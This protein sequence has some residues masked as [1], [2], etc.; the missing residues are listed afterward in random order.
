M[1]FISS[2]DSDG[3]HL[4]HSKSDNRNIMTGFD[5]VENIEELFDLLA[6]MY[7]VD[8]EKSM[9]GSE[10]VFECIDG[11]YYKCHKVSLNRGGSYIN[12]HK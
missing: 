5:T 11:F 8:L 7:Q 1:K 4:M 12:S 2:E 3:K 10:F 9:K 6:Q